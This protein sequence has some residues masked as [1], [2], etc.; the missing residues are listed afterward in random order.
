[1]LNLHF[2]HQPKRL[3]S[4]ADGEVHLWL[5]DLDQSE[6]DHELLPA[7]TIERIHRLRSAQARRR[8]AAS[9]VAMRT[10]LGKYLHLNS[11]QLTFEYGASGK[12]SLTNHALQFNLTHSSH[13]ACLAVSQQ[14]IGVDLEQIA[15]VSNATKI[16]KRKFPPRT[17]AIVARAKPTQQTLIFL[18]HWTRYESQVKLKGGSIFVAKHADIDPTI[19]F[20]TN[21]THIG[22]ISTE[23]PFKALTSFVYLG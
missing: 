13:L 12:P 2:S 9:T 3:T 16:A 22:A 21:N 11:N 14:P 23:H 18:R 19:S 6:P 17:A 7:S 5:I 8:K 10:I 1:M 15:A 4:P 20:T